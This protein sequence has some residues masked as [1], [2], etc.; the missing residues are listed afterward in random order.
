MEH[1]FD[2]VTLNAQPFRYRVLTEWKILIKK[3]KESEN[4]D[5]MK[6]FNTIKTA[7]DFQQIIEAIQKYQ[8]ENTKNDKDTTDDLNIKLHEKLIFEIGAPWNWIYRFV[9]HNSSHIKSYNFCECIVQN[10]SSK[11]ETIA[12]LNEPFECFVTQMPGIGS[13]ISSET[14]QNFLNF[15]ESQ[16]NDDGLMFPKHFNDTNCPPIF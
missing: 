13:S 15:I 2:V 6:T 10:A 8:C 7:K 16:I 9:S 3:P 14:V 5:F 11:D 4:S 1:N 12:A